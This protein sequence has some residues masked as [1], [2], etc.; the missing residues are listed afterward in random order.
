MLI[1]GFKD[2][3]AV[4]AVTDIEFKEAATLKEYLKVSYDC[5]GTN[6]IERVFTSVRL[7]FQDPSKFLAA[8]PAAAAPTAAKDEPKKEE[9]KEESEEE[10]ED[11]GF[12]LFD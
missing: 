12:G 5:V 7:I 8:A 2:V 9:K 6:E 3:L 1:N 10:D 4:A 11:M